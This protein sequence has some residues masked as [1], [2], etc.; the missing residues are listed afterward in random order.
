MNFD[1]KALLTGAAIVAV[2]AIFFAIGRSGDEGRIHRRLDELV[3]LVNKEGPES[4][5]ESAGKARRIVSYFVEQPRVRALPNQGVARARDQISGVLMAVRNHASTIEVSL[6][7]R[8]IQVSEDGERAM[9]YFTGSADV[10]YPSGRDTHR[11]N[12]VMEM[13]KQDGEWLIASVNWEE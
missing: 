3:A 8:R 9:V 4:Q 10:V 11:A 13:I 7:N 6:R 2:A 12:Y 1:R 5:I